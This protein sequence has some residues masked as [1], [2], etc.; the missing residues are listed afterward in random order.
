M[1]AKKV[2]VFSAIM[3]GFSYMI[4]FIGLKPHRC[5]TE[6]I[7][8][9]SEDGNIYSVYNCESD[10]HQITH[11]GTKENNYYFFSNEMWS[12]DGEKV[13]IGKNGHGYVLDINQTIIIDIGNWVENMVWSENDKYILVTQSKGGD[14]YVVDKQLTVVDENTF[15]HIYETTGTGGLWINNFEIL[16][17]QVESIHNPGGS[18]LQNLEV[19]NIST[20]NINKLPIQIDS[21]IAP[22]RE[23][24]L[25]PSGKYLA[26]MS[27]SP[28]SLTV[29]DMNKNK[30]YKS[31]TSVYIGENP[32]SGLISNGFNWALENDVMVFCHF[33]EQSIYVIEGEENIRKLGDQSCGYSSN[34]EWM[35]DN[36][37]SVE[38]HTRQIGIYCLDGTKELLNLFPEFL[39]VDRG[40]WWSPD[41]NRVT[42]I[43]DKGLYMANYSKGD[44]NLEFEFFNDAI[45]F[46]WAPKKSWFQSMFK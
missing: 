28:L 43:S 46:S 13:L 4:W 7:Y 32:E 45:S 41:K 40:P 9:S 21:Y 11:D 33:F 14:P 2:R 37:F 12:A 34:L 31:Q 44:I 22:I 19:I 20:K 26:A 23:G 6:F 36:C 18:Y 24:R 5:V 10:I 8:I 38:T 1:D 35:N 15:E 3:L 39:Q 30:S 27:P 29:V 42:I 16:T 17:F 25:S